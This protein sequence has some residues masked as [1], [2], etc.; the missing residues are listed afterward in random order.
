[1]SNDELQLS[2]VFRW[3]VKA[4][5]RLVII[6]GSFLSLE[7]FMFLQWCGLFE[8]RIQNSP[9]P[10]RYVSGGCYLASV[11]LS[12]LIRLKR[13]EWVGNISLFPCIR[14]TFGAKKRVERSTIVAD[15]SGLG[16]SF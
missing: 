15:L 11:V 8:F 7:F 5:L 4:V 10:L 2:R 6:R 14:V 3:L 9:H 16:L 1:V 12:G 13:M